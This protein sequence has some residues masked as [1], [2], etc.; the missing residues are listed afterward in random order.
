MLQKLFRER[1]RGDANVEEG[2]GGL[3]MRI[4]TK[5]L[6]RQRETQGFGNM[7][8]VEKVFIRICSQQAKRISDER[9]RNQQADDFLFTKEDLIGPEPSAAVLES[10]AWSKLQSLIGLEGVK[11]NVQT[12][13]SILTTN[14]MR[15]LK[16][17]EP[18]QV[19][20][21]K[22]FLGSPGTGKESRTVARMRGY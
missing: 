5:R 1:F 18:I 19:S 21:N 11:E 6:S 2:L 13:V 16:E 3:Y 22:V 10:P 7:R 12:L 8:D 20:L 14:Y 15:E 9:R 4:V 17:K